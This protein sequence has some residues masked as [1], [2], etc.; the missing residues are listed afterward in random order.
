MALP[1]VANA[2]S[3]YRVHV[4][5]IASV[6]DVARV[7]VGAALP[8]LT[9]SD[10]RVCFKD[11]GLDFIRRECKGIFPLILL[12]VVHEFNLLITTHDFRLRTACTTYRTTIAKQNT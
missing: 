7:F 5:P 3:I 8:P 4:L 10:R 12:R 1:C 6:H 2:T 11:W 9:K